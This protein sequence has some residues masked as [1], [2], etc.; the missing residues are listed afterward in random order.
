MS[1]SIETS[2]ITLAAMPR[3][4]LIM[5]VMLAAFALAGFAIFVVYSMARE[6]GKK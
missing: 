5:L 4:S 3:E 1:E 2:L 6:R